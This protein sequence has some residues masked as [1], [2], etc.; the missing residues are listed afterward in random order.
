MND[1]NCKAYRDH[2]TD[3]IVCDRCG[4]QW[5]SDDDDPPKCKPYHKQK[6]STETGKCEMMKIR[7]SLDNAKIK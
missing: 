7:E 2:G 1:S 6:A 3:T 4:Y 5:G